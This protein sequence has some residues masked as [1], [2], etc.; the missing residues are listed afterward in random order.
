MG[1]PRK[2]QPILGSRLKDLRMSRGMSLKEVSEETGMSTS[3]LSLVETGRNEPTAGRLVSL[4][5]FFEVELEDVI[6]E[7]EMEGPVVLRVDDRQ[8]LSSGDPSVR[9]EPLASWTFSEMT[10][11]SVRFDAGAE[12]S[13]AASPAG[14][15]FALLL[16]GE[17]QI[18]FSDETSLV[19]RQGDSVCFE[20]SRRHRCVN[21][22]ETEAHVI[23]FKNEPRR[24]LE[25]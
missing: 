23:T 17:L 22:G 15:E 21:V 9:T 13:V 2:P 10:T 1:T 8:V 6:P 20:A 3:Y 5:D 25:S 24:G 14:P 7:R 12:L 16:A 4:L 11:A 18:D 19:L